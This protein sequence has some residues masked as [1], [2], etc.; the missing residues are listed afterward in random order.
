MA[1]SIILGLFRHALASSM[2]LGSIQSV[3]SYTTLPIYTC[4]VKKSAVVRV[5]CGVLLELAV[6]STLSY[7]QL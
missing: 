5:G 6:V 3:L 4:P 1:N 2:Y 7:G